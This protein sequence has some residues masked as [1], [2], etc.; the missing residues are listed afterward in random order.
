MP[1]LIR[2]YAEWS[3]AEGQPNT[4]IHVTANVGPNT[5]IEDNAKVGPHCTVSGTAR[6][7]G[8]S[9]LY[10][11]DGCT[12]GPVV[13]GAAEILGASVIVGRV[14]VS[15][16][17]Y[18]H[19]GRLRNCAI[20]RGNATVLRSTIAGSA[21]VSG[22][23]SVCDSQV[24][25]SVVIRDSANVSDAYIYGNAVLSKDAVA[26]NVSLCDSLTGPAPVVLNVCRWP[27][28]MVSKDYVRVGC[29]RHIISDWLSNQ[30]NVVPWDKFGVGAQE[31]L[32][33]QTA[34]RLMV[35][36]AADRKIWPAE[37]RT[38]SKRTSSKRPSSKRT[39]SKRTSSKRPVA[40]ISK[41]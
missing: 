6:I 13:A 19:T 23:A 24:A 37:K 7:A 27:I 20:V 17:A 3:C 41:P 4:R 16:H 39:S 31:K 11:V 26:S 12:I 38:S 8:T 15:G 14:K 25:D 40:S 32:R 30:D 29:Q 10:P 35:E 34:I 2:I 33:I 5:R 9:V 21:E 36:T 22:N 1:K 28:S 18:I